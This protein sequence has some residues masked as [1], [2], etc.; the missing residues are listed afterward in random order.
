MVMTA[1]VIQHDGGGGIICIRRW[2]Y[3]MAEVSFDGRG[4]K[5]WWRRRYCDGRGGTIYDSGMT[6]AVECIGGGTTVI[7]Y[8]MA[9]AILHGGGS[10]ICLSGGDFI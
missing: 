1:A 9:A 7:C 5:I 6:A 3:L 4:A 8:N 2:Y 10:I